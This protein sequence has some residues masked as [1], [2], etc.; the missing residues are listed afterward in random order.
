MSMY[1]RERSSDEMADVVLHYTRNAEPPLRMHNPAGSSI[2]TVT[3][4]L[5]KYEANVSYY[6]LVE[7]ILLTRAGRE[8]VK[9][10]MKQEAGE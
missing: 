5:G 4:G 2:G 3:V 7:A 6:D 10:V 8:A 9:H 1:S